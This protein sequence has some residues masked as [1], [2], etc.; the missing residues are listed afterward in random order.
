MAGAILRKLGDISLGGDQTTRTWS[1]A[2]SEWSDDDEVPV[3]PPPST[4]VPPPSTRVEE[5]SMGG[6][7]VPQKQAMEVP[8][9]QARGAPER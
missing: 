4:K 2:M 6:E 7:E 5:Q 9:Q 8:E 3:A 1:T